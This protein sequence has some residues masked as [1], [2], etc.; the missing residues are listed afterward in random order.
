MHPTEPSAH[1]A[2]ALSIDAALRASKG[3]PEDG[4]PLL[5]QTDRGYGDGE[6][7]WFS[8]AHRWAA[9]HVARIGD[10]EERAADLLERAAGWL[11][12]C[13]VVA[14]ECQIL[15]DTVEALVD[16]GRTER[17]RSW[18]AR[19]AEL[20]ERLRT[21]LAAAVAAHTTAIV[22]RSREGLCV[23]AEGY[24][25]IGAPPL[26]ARALERA[27][28]LAEDA[29][30]TADLVEA[31]RAYAS[32]PAPALAE[33]VRAELRRRGPS[34]RRAA[35]GVGELTP[36]EREV[37][38]LAR[39][40]SS[41]REIAEQLHLSERTVESHLARVYAKLGISGRKELG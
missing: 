11:R 3:T 27:G 2:W 39:R 7:Y 9:A 38:A 41:T 22:E 12:R 31:A 33:R 26:R 8:A 24:A 30:A 15:P 36:R 10:D 32:L 17:A 23:A 21:P 19:G 29:A 13:D 34:G 37:A 1:S 20:A 28:G 40:G 16:A 35:Q 25:T 4:R 18:S 5:G 14:V 6:F